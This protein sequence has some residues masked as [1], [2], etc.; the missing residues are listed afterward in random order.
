[1]TMENSVEQKKN[2]MMGARAR[3][4][5]ASVQSVVGRV[6]NGR[7]W[8]FQ[9]QRT[10][11]RYNG[12]VQYVKSFDF[13]VTNVTK[14]GRLQIHALNSTIALSQISCLLASAIHNE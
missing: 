1:M 4:P 8:A 3:C 7:I 9:A 5:V 11:T 6:G 2:K 12:M 14:L 13:R 10:C